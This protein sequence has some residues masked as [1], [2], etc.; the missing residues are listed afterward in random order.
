MVI[1]Q[2]LNK[3]KQTK[4]VSKNLRYKISFQVPSLL[5]FGIMHMSISNLDD[6][7]NCAKFTDAI[8]KIDNSFPIHH[9]AC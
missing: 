2:I 7:H 6:I 8:F 3:L 9:S 5:T 4:F 1:Y